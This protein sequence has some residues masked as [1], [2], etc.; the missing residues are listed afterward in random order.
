MNDVNDELEKPLTAQNSNL[1]EL[2]RRIRV[3][4]AREGK[5]APKAALEAMLEEI[6]HKH[7]YGYRR[8]WDILVELIADHL[9]IIAEPWKYSLPKATVVYDNMKRLGWIRQTQTTYPE[10]AKHIENTGLMEEYI[11]SAERDQWDYLGD[12]FVE[13]ELAGRQNRLGQCLTPKG[14]VDFMIKCLGVCETKKKPDEET[15]GWLISE[16]W[17]H[18]LDILKN[19]T[20]LRIEY[21]RR[22]LDLPPVWKKY[23]VKP[24]TYLDPAVGT[25]RFLIEASTLNPTAPLVLFGIEIDVTLYRA[26]LVNMAMFSKHPYSIICGDTLMFDVDK[27]GPASGLWDRGNLWEPIDVS[28]FY[29]KPPPINAHHFSLK[30]F[31]E[32]KN[33]STETNEKFDKAV[34]NPPWNDKS[35]S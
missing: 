21:Q 32:I 13:R 1:D 27:A 26:C 4:R 15:L 9:G 28:M 6:E 2:L 8:S 7:Y 35:K 19:S 33:A 23:A 20:N 14:I 16:N 25:G 3:T 12:I 29:A 11:A 34:A 24:K 17:A 5:T 18:E 30:A 31:T 22:S 10:L